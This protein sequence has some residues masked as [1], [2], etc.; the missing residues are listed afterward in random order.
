MLEII[1]GNIWDYHSKGHFIVIPINIGW[2]RDGTNVCGRGLAAQTASMFPDIPAQIGECCRAAIDLQSNLLPGKFPAVSMNKKLIFF[3]TKPL[4]KRN[5]SLSWKHPSDLE[6]IGQMAEALNDMV[7]SKPK[8]FGRV[9]LP[10]VGAGNGG[11]D[12]EEVLNV[13][14]LKLCDKNFTIVDWA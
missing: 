3:P 5:A 12:K 7:T 2:K 11:L 8:I 10:I 9:Y 13:L 1:K 4:D 14:R 6:L